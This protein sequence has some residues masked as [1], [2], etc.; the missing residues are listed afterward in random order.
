MKVAP[1]PDLVTVSQPVSIEIPKSS[2][3]SSIRSKSSKVSLKSMSIAPE[4][5]EA[6]LVCC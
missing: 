1:Q 2:S 4:V 3:K 6:M 5:N